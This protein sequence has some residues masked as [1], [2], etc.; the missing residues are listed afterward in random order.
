MPASTFQTYVYTFIHTSIT[1]KHVRTFLRT[2]DERDLRNSYACEGIQ[3]YQGTELEVFTLKLQLFI[4]IP[5]G[6]HEFVV[7][8]A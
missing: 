7:P 6:V 8:T 5:V 1:H 4:K 3:F 2:W